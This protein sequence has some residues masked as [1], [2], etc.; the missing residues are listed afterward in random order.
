MPEMKVLTYGADGLQNGWLM[1]L[2]KD[3]DKTVSYLTTVFPGGFKGYHL[4]RIRQANYVC[5]KGQVLVT[6][7]HWRGGWDKRERILRCGDTMN[8]SVNVPT[9]L[10]NLG[11]EEAWIVN[12]PNPA[13]DPN[14]KEQ[15]EYTIVELCRGIRK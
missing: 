11:K 2:Q 12:F 3:G 4:H 10:L 9:G 6:T 15:V 14:V 1:E 5:L 7:F 13:Y 8:I